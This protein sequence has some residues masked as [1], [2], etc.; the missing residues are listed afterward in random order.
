MKKGRVFL[1]L[2]IIAIVLS[3][4]SKSAPKNT[5]EKIDKNAGI[6]NS[7]TDINTEGISEESASPNEDRNV[8]SIAQEFASV[9]KNKVTFD[10]TYN[11][12]YTNKDIIWEYRGYLKDINFFDSLLN[13]QS[14]SIVD[15]DNDAVPEVILEIEEYTGFI[16]LRY[17]K[18]NIYGNIVGYRSM[19]C[20]KEN[21]FFMS[22]SSSDEDGW[23]KLYF[24]GN[25]FIEDKTLFRS[26]TSY[27]SEDKYIDEKQWWEIYHTF[28]SLEDVEWYD[29]SDKSIQR[30]ILENPVFDCTLSEDVSSIDER[31]NYLD[32]LSYLI[33]MTYDDTKKTQEERN[34]SAREYYQCCQKEL[35]TIYQLYFESLSEDETE[36]VAAEQQEWKKNFDRRMQME[37]KNLQTDRIET[38]EDQ[39]L[40][41]TLGDIILRRICY[42]VNAYL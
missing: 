12:P 26:S 5:M 27:Y 23:N 17:E 41:Y 10:C 8:G 29:Y 33:E 39:S 36:K 9:L 32:S 28:D 18:E 7:G 30:R 3:A 20:L 6:L 16:V 24:I 15:L 38:L 1:I 34:A 14:F 13:I 19:Y 42:L 37:L 31:Q 2:L 35:N 25:T 4:C 21:G 11:I 22:S 40:Y